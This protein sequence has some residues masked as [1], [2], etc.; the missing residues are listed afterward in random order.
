MLVARATSSAADSNTIHDAVWTIW[1]T[2]SQRLVWLDRGLSSLER[3]DAGALI[4]LVS[5]DPPPGFVDELL[6][7]VTADEPTQRANALQVLLA[8]TDPEIVLPLADAAPHTQRA[9]ARWATRQACAIAGVDTVDWIAAAPT[10]LDRGEPLPAPFDD[11]H[12]M[13][14]RLGPT[15]AYPTPRLRSR[16][17]LPT[18][19]SKRSRCRRYPPPRTRTPSPAPSTPSTSPRSPTATA[20]EIAHRHHQRTRR[21]PATCPRR[22]PAA[23]SGQRANGRV[24]GRFVAGG[25]GWPG[26]HCPRDEDAA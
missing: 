20:T 9:V 21:R 4:R 26:A 7:A 16:P 11:P 8:T 5:A 14:E 13:S 3:N 17:A 22:R 12:Q 1:Q 6:A 2:Y 10:A 19:P 24:S 18:A 23:E 15:N 25:A